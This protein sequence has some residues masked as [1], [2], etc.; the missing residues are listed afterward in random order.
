MFQ[1]ASVTI[2]THYR[3]VCGSCGADET[4]VFLRLVVKMSDWL[5]EYRTNIKFCVK[6][7]MN[8]S[9]TFTILFEVCGGDA[10]KK[11]NGFEKHKRFKDGRGD[12]EDDERSGRPRYHGTD[13]NVEKVRNLV[14]SDRLKFKCQ[15][16]GYTNKLR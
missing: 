7:G 16:Y 9:D 11:S 2:S 1:L 15:S 12:V 6:L 8:A 3:Q 14:H 13:E 10:M 5:L 4:C